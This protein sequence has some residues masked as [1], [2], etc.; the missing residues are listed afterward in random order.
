LKVLHII[1]TL[2]SSAGGPSEVALN[3][4]RN[5]NS[6]GAEAEILNNGLTMAMA[7]LKFLLK[8]LLFIKKLLFVFFQG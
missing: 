5:L 4:V 7:G 8:R 1:P 2:S 6:L 3:L